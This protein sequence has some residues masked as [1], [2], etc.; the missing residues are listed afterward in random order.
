MSPNKSTLGQLTALGGQPKLPPSHT[1]PLIHPKCYRP[2]GNYSAVDAVL[3]NNNNKDSA[4]RASQQQFVA[5]ILPGVGSPSHSYWLT[6]QD[7]VGE[8]LDL[9]PITGHM[10]IKA[11][12]DND[13]TRQWI[14]KVERGGLRSFELRVMVGEAAH[15]VADCACA[16]GR[17]TPWEIVSLFLKGLEKLDDVIKLLEG[18]TELVTENPELRPDYECVLTSA[19]FGAVTIQHTIF[20]S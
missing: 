19:D 12:A 7:R 4:V 20:Q 11:L 14:E 15:F 1:V 18:N 9:D 17:D 6:L 13:T 10:L 3:A 8:F 16:L 5:K 2:I